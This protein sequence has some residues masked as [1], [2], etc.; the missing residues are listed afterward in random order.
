MTSWLPCVPVTRS[1]DWRLVY[2]FTHCATIITLTELTASATS[3][4]TTRLCEAGSRDEERADGCC[5]HFKTDLIDGAQPWFWFL[6]GGD[7]MLR[8][9]CWVKLATRCLINQ[10]PSALPC[11][12]C[13]GLFSGFSRRRRYD[14]N[15]CGRQSGDARKRERGEDESGGE[16]CSPSLLGGPV[17]EYHRC[18]FCCQANPGG[19]ESDYSWN[20]GHSWIRALRSHEQNLLQ[21]SSSRHRLLWSDWQQQLPAS[22]LLGQRAAKL[23]GAL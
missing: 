3:T 8:E 13:R 21:R 15:A 5:V 10:L 6:L 22:S 9:I 23:R 4:N 17:P 14:R 16:I 11:L 18:C 12:L 2:N 19:R 7:L 20:M 1:A